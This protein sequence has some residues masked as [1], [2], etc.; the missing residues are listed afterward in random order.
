MYPF[1]C[2]DYKYCL[3]SFHFE[4]CFTKHKISDILSTPCFGIKHVLLSQLF[5][6]HLERSNLE[7]KI[8]LTM[9]LLEIMYPL[10]TMEIL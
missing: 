7:L 4:H 6:K 3:T 8:L 5:L 1:K 10:E 9:M 2:F